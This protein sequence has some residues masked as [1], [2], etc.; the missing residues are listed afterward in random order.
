MS[1]TTPAPVA[2]R[3]PVQREVTVSGRRDVGAYVELTLDA[4]DI[5]E[6]AQP[7]QFVAF[8]VGGPLSA[9]LLR[10]SIAIAGAADGAVTVVVAAHGPGSSWLAQRR[11]G[12]RRRRGRA[13]G[14]AV[15]AAR[16]RRL[17]RCWW[18]VGTGRPPSSG[19]PRC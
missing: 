15:P 19:W 7:G 1:L 16:P 11:S 9:N 5:A 10:R 17:G 14:P 12:R 2:D 4:P 3:P 8:A 13:A 18:V 6:R